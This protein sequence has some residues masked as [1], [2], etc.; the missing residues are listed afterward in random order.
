MFNPECCSDKELTQFKFM[1]IMFG[2]AIRTRRPL[3]LHLASPMWKLLA[4]MRLTSE[5][6]EEV[7]EREKVVGVWVVN[8]S[9]FSQVDLMFTQ[10]LYSIRD[11][12]KGDISEDDFS[13][14]K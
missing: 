10:T 5:D 2:V 12:H 13:E 4:G 3:D 8:V 1:G 9:L 14:V 7:W 11:V 6:L